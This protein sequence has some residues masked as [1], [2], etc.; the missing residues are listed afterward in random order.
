[1]KFVFLALLVSGCASVENTEVGNGQYMATASSRGTGS[2]STSAIN[3]AMGAAKKQCS[4]KAV[5]V[6][7]LANGGGWPVATTATLIYE[8][9]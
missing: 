9:K 8:C 3:D 1:M 4:D 7:N 2:D 6:V 5:K